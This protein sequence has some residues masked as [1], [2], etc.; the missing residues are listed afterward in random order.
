[1]KI[2]NINNS[3][4]VQKFQ[5]FKG[6]KEIA[7]QDEDKNNKDEG[8]TVFISPACYQAAKNISLSKNIGLKIKPIEIELRDGEKYT[9][10]I[11]HSTAEDYLQ[12]KDGGLDRV[13]VQNF[14]QIYKAALQ[15]LTD[16]ENDFTQNGLKLLLGGK[17]SE[18]KNIKEVAAHILNTS[19]ERRN[20]F[21]GEAYK[22]AEAIFEFSKLSKGKYDGFRDLNGKVEVTDYIDRINNNFP[23]SNMLFG[24]NKISRDEN[25]VFDSG[26][27]KRLCKILLASDF[28]LSSYRTG[29][30]LKHFVEK[31]PKNADK[32]T[33]AIIKVDHSGFL[34]YD[35]SKS[36]EQ[37]IEQCFDSDKTFS[38]I[39]YQTLLSAIESVQNC[40]SFGSIWENMA[41]GA[42]DE[43]VK[44]ATNAIAEYFDEIK[45]KNGGIEPEKCNPDEFFARRE[46]E[47]AM[48][49]L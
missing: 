39:R 33:D 16:K 36:F 22:A 17:D 20:Y 23:R 4:N 28:E 49:F 19:G 31:D 26:F 10:A 37:L 40:W 15:R 41:I 12:G 46:K 14:A 29:E 1:M 44:Y 34:L 24:I 11:S 21:E 18:N 25:G 7:P 38:E 5:N 45:D 43:W 30:M 42:D 9:L 6:T 27:A 13:L 35:D 47:V 48:L 3:Y 32:I 8:T 2:S